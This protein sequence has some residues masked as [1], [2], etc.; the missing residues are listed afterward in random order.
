MSSSILSVVLEAR[1]CLIFYEKYLH[2]HFFKITDKIY[3]EREQF[4]YTLRRNVS[5][6]PHIYQI[7]VI[8]SHTVTTSIARVNKFSVVYVKIGL[9]CN[10]YAAAYDDE[11]C[12]ICSI[13]SLLNLF[14]CVI[15]WR[16]RCTVR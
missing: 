7:I 12:C 2:E 1:S 14:L 8:R 4:M 11:S 15:H 9:V 5:H 3:A 6:I 16:W 13:A 10:N